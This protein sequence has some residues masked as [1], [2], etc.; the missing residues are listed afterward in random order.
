MFLIL[1]SGYLDEDSRDNL[2]NTEVTV[3]FFNPTNRPKIYID[4][5]ASD[6]RRVELRFIF[7]RIKPADAPVPVGTGR[8]FQ[9]NIAPDLQK[10][11]DDY[12]RKFFK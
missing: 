6:V 9:M 7:A 2:P 3:K 11:Y 12:Y 1:S 8:Y 10:M 5:S 4:K